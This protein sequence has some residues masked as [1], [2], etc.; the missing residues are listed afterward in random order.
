MIVST[1][2][3]PLALLAVMAAA[4]VLGAEA[5]L[6]ESKAP[7][8]PTETTGAVTWSAGTDEDGRPVLNGHVAIGKGRLAAELTFR[9]MTD[10]TFPADYV[11]EV[12]FVP[13]SE[14]TEG[15][16]AELKGVLVRMYMEQGAP[17]EGATA[18]VVGNSFLFA[19]RQ[20]G[21]VDILT[22]GN[23][24]DFAVIY[25]TGRRAILGV[26]VDEKARDTLAEMLL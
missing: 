12:T 25:E 13:Q 11:I 22:T 21:N 7:F 19:A 3:R 20:G 2:V 10:P 16:V 1:F 17:V 8:T 5:V 9:R 15:S 18:R 24:I 26:G 6:L 23:W 4:P 14:F